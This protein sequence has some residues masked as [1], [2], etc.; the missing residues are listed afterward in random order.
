MAFNSLLEAFV[1]VVGIAKRVRE[2][3]STGYD[4]STIGRPKTKPGT[5]VKGG[6]ANRI[7]NPLVGQSASTARY[8]QPRTRMALMA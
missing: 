4:N 5:R 2:G 7:L 6:A 1:P 3:G 8:S